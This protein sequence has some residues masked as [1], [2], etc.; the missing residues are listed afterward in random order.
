MTA[1]VN[2]ENGI[3]LTSMV[4]EFNRNIYCQRADTLYPLL[5]QLTECKVCVKG[6]TAK[7]TQE[8]VSRLACELAGYEAR[9]VQLFFDAGE[10]QDTLSYCWSEFQL[11]MGLH[12]ENVEACPAHFDIGKQIDC[13]REHE[14][15]L[16]ENLTSRLQAIEEFAGLIE[17]MFK[18]TGKLN[19]GALGCQLVEMLK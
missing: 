10:T 17:T 8:F 7:S 1:I 18:T 15:E 5:R 2:S 19:V 12:Y 16:R 6:A 11:H 13:L 3:T 9:S 4:E 14:E